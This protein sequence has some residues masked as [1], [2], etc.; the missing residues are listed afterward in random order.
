MPLWNTCEMRRLAL[1]LVLLAM[2]VGASACA[3][4]KHE[5]EQAAAA[6]AKPPLA[7]KEHTATLKIA[8]GAKVIARKVLPEGFAPVPPFAPI[9]LQ[10]GA[11]IAVVG[12]KAGRA[13]VVKFDAATLEKPQIVA[14][15]FG[16][17]AP[18]G[19]IVDVEASPDG[20]ELAIAVA[21]PA[22]NQLEI[23]LHDVVAQGEGSRIASFP[24]QFDSVSMS[25]LDG[26][27]IALALRAGGVQPAPTP[28]AQPV[29]Q[30]SANGGLFMIETT[31][32][33]AVK[34]MKLNCPLSHLT[35]SRDGRFAI[36]G[37]D[38][39]TPPVLIDRARDFCAVLRSKEPIMVLAWSPHNDGFLYS[40]PTANTIATFRYHLAT[41]KSALIAI[42]SSAAAFMSSGQVF[43]LGN[44]DLSWRRV[45]EAPDAPVLSE[46]AT[47]TPEAGEVRIVPLGIRTIPAMLAASR[48]VYTTTT[49]SAAVDIISPGRPD[50]LREVIAYLLPPSTA[51]LMA[52]GPARG[53]VLMSWSPDGKN[54]AMVDGDQKSSVLTIFSPAAELMAPPPAPEA[55]KPATPA[56]PAPQRPP[57]PVPRHDT[58]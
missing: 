39:G 2:T 29:A 21:E 12:T 46:F 58:P 1:I 7:P 8:T 27:T 52:S 18:G 3:S 24:G 38:P 47:F 43:A 34:Q 10:N 30:S 36:G 57:R 15:D 17:G 5:A 50:P 51:F 25:W 48:I 11:Q 35:W 9:W 42:S 20:M 37:G 13:F 49:D 54:L 23:V 41:G 14:S 6:A 32:L 19:S 22:N 28:G 45:A 31:G 26:H 53:G 33:G 56:E 16:P 40:M 44:Q 55:A 4:K